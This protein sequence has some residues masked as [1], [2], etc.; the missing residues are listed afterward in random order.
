MLSLFFG[1][2]DVN[3]FKELR[4]LIFFLPNLK[5][6]IAAISCL[7]WDFFYIL[8]NIFVLLFIIYFYFDY[9]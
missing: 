8:K 6:N 5:Q 9:F 7:Q 4:M 2:Q 3:T 1:E